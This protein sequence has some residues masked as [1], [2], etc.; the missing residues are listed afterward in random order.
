MVEDDPDVRALMS[1]V[2]ERA[3]YAVDCAGTLTGAEMLLADQIYDALIVDAMLPD[4][5]ALAKAVR[6]AA[7]GHKTV[8]V[9]GFPQ[10]MIDLEA[11]G[12]RYLRKPFKPD[13]VIGEVERL[14][15]A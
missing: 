7:G 8:I 4:G 11:L 5:S 10:A 13:Q 1:V 6:W 2:L 9:T 12:V 3:G 15:S 14:L